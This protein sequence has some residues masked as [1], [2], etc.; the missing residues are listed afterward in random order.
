MRVG[1][2]V[3]LL[4]TTLILAAGLAGCGGNNGADNEG[5]N[6][7][8]TNN[9]AAENGAANNGAGNG[10]G[11]AGGATVDTAA[12]EAIY[13]ANCVGCHAADMSGGVGPNLQKVGGKLSTEEIKS[14]IA[15]GG[16]GMPAYK[17]QLSS[18]EIDNLTNWLAAMK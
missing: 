5:T 3:L 12:A 1:K 15:N 17:D 13:K 14:R 4:A 8:T 2:G 10:A 18:A 9:G 11:N 6:K 7:G 16:G